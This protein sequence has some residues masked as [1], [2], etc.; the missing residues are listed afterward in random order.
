MSTSTS[1][2]TKQVILDRP[3]DWQ[4][5]LFIVKTMAEG[6][7]VWRYI[8]PEIDTP[9]VIPPRPIKPTIQQIKAAA[10]SL[11]DLAVEERDLYKL[12]LA[13]YKEDQLINK[14]IRD[15]IQRILDHM[16]TTVSKDNL[17]IIEDLSSVHT[18]L[19]ELR[20][21][22][23]PKNQ[24]RK[25][26]VIDQY[27]KLK[28]YNKRQEVEKWLRAWEVTYSEAVKLDLPEVVDERSLF[29]FT[30]AIQSLDSVYSS[31]QEYILQEKVDNSDELPTLF[32]LIEKFRNHQRRTP[33]SAR[34]SS[35]VAFSA[36]RGEDIDGNVMCICGQKHR[37]EH[38]EYITLATR[39]KGWQGKPEVFD[40]INKYLKAK[41]S[42]LQWF[43]NEFKYDGKG[44]GTK[45]G[46]NSTGPNS[47]STGSKPQD[48]PPLAVTVALSP[49]TTSRGTPTTLAPLTTFATS[50]IGEY[51]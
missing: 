12:M 27:Q 8:N 21:R 33:Q 9:P 4:P 15:A 6:S 34:N 5:W 3:K 25:L 35:N 38:C 29:D 1:S 48:Q 20:R 39:P 26:E 40:H 10:T 32:A 42:R 47:N 46:S 16:V 28:V 11:V 30:R 45:T 49:R 7:D 13:D 19:I 50:D 14:Q 23:A 37:Y 2:T 31:T 17:Y 24:A 44:K 51:R 43:L 36:L 22:L 41:P 18:M